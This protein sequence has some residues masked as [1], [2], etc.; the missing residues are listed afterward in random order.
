M[1]RRSGREGTDIPVETVRR[2]ATG[3]SFS[4]AQGKEIGLVDEL[5]DFDTR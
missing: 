1:V 3:E 4:A 5:G 2:Y